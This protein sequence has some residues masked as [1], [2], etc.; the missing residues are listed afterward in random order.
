MPPEGVS[1]DTHT[2]ESSRSTGVVNSAELEGTFRIFLF[3]K[4]HSYVQ[5]VHL[6]IC[7]VCQL[8]EKDNLRIREMHEN[9]EFE[10]EP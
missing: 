4:G 7:M 3:E 10:N 6:C 9:W 2:E 8:A 1:D 5:Q